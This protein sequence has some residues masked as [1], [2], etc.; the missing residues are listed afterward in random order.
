[1]REGEVNVVDFFRA[2]ARNWRVVAAWAL[3][4]A[5][6]VAAYTFV[7]PARWAARAALLLPIPEA[8]VQ[9]DVA[10]FAFMP[11]GA[12]PASMLRA[13]IESRTA[14]AEVAEATQLTPRQVRAMLSVEE[15]LQRSLLMIAA[16]SNDKR[17]ALTAVRTAVASLQR[18]EREVGFSIASKQATILEGAVA[19]KRREL[20]AAE[21][22]LLAY[23]KRMTTIPDDGEG[24]S[25]AGYVERLQELDLELESVKKELEVQKRLAAGRLPEPEL[26]TGLP[27]LDRWRERLRDAEFKLDLERTRFRDDAP[28]VR[29]LAREVEVARG[30]LEKEVAAFVRSMHET[31]NDKTAEL[32]ARRLVLELQVQTARELAARAPG[33]AVEFRRHLRAVNNAAETYRRVLTDFEIARTQA[34][35]SRVR[36]TVLDGPYVEDRPVNKSFARNTAFG[37]ILG[38]VIGLFVAAGRR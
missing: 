38:L 2:A 16:E 12:Q 1:M 32:E 36:W 4:L 26:P 18:I 35:A 24:Q 14:I 34:E 13:V 15:D 10:G 21:E 25:V 3:I 33:E 17:Q 20:A 23:Q 29:A 8:G 19:T 30:A 6:G 7:V 27:Q 22:R 37:L 9:G 28:T 11:G 31:I 5:V